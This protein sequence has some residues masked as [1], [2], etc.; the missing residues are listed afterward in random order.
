MS[1]WRTARLME[2]RSSEMKL[3]G[4]LSRAREGGLLDGD[5]DLLGDHG[6]VVRNVVRIAQQQLQG[7]LARG[8]RHGRLGLRLAEVNDLVRYGRQRLALARR[9]FGVD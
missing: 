7:V 4:T 1:T 2:R 3:R 9:H 8:Q 6:W 5:G